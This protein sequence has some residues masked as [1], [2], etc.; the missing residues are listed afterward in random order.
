LTQDYVVVEAPSVLGLWPSGVER[1]PEALKA[2]GLLTGLNARQGARLESDAYSKV[3]D[4]ASGFLNGPG[5]RRFSI[6]LADVLEEVWKSGLVPV[7]LGGDCSILIGAAVGLRRRGRYGLLFIDAHA[8]YYGPHQSPT[9]EVADMDLAVVTGASDEL[10]A[11]IGNLKPYFRADDVVSFG[12]R[13]EHFWGADGSQ[14]IRES[15]ATFIDLKTIRSDLFA[16]AVG[17][18]RQALARPELDGIF[19]HFDADALADDIMPAVDYR[20]EGGLTLD[21]AAALLQ[22]ARETEKFVGISV[23]IFNPS[24]DADGTIARSLSDCL[25]SGLRG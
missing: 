20:L 21:E 13:D 18:A 17:K 22:M 12:C 7:V 4:P 1:L 23:T 6:A 24:L 11:N 19:V 25:V 15:G 8:D 2:Q 5:I 9:G 3:R 14:N 16:N 10:L